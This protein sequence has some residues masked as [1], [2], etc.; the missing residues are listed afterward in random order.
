M[1]RETEEA[2]FL[3]FSQIRSSTC[4]KTSATGNYRKLNASAVGAGTGEISVVSQDDEEKLWE[5]L[6]FPVAAGGGS[7][8]GSCGGGGCTGGCCP[9]SSG[10]YSYY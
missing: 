5:N 8:D 6:P 1:G 4:W 2:P 7:G 9:C 3:L 10:T